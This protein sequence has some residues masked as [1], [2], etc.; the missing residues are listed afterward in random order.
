MKKF[1][2]L[3]SLLLVSANAK[4]LTLSVTSSTPVYGKGNCSDG[5]ST[6][7]SRAAGSVAEDVGDEASR[8]AGNAVGDAIGGYAGGFIGKAIK[9]IGW[10]ESTHQSDKLERNMEAKNCRGGIIGY[11][12]TAF[13]NGKKYTQFS[14]TKLSQIRVN[15]K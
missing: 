11:N 5:G 14:K 1:L 3:T 12:N 13:Y 10:K 15:V 4:M 2:L 8:Q 9:H 6:M 7:G